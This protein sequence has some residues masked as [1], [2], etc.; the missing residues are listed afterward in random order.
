MVAQPGKK[1]HRIGDEINRVGDMDEVVA[2]GDLDFL[3]LADASA[4]TE[5]AVE[6][7]HCRIGIDAFRP[8]QP[9]STKYRT[10]SPSP[11]AASRNRRPAL[12][13]QG[14]AESLIGT[15]GVALHGQASLP[16]VRGP[17]LVACIDDARRF[18][19]RSRTPRSG[20]AVG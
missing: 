8:S 3:D 7:K 6:S 5:V 11:Q 16:Q 18:Q 19:M 13:S 14:A 17:R 9:R 1:S 2:A 10:V 20:A 15:L 4:D 12:D